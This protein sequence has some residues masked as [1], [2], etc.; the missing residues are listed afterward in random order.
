MTDAQGNS[1][2]AVR[3]PRRPLEVAACA[4]LLCAGILVNYDKFATTPTARE[5]LG[6]NDAWQYFGPSA[7][8]LDRSLHHGEF[9]LWNP[10]VYCG[11]PF[12]ANPQSKSFYPP[13][14]VRS[15]LTWDPTPEASHRS[16]K[17]LLFVHIALGG[18][19][20]FCLARTLGLSASAAMLAGYVFVFNSQF[21]RR[22]VAHHYIDALVW[23]PWVLLFLEWACAATSRAARA[24]FIVCGAFALGMSALAGYPQTTIYVGLATLAYAAFRRIPG[25]HAGTPRGPGPLRGV[26]AD[27]GI[28]AAVSLGAIL[29]ASVAIVPAIELFALSS[30]GSHGV[31][32]K[33]TGLEITTLSDVGRVFF[34]YAGPERITVGLLSGVAGVLVLMSLWT[35]R[36]RQAAVWAAVMLPLADLAIGTPM[37]FSTLLLEYLPFSL[38]QPQRMFAILFLPLGILAG[39]GLDAFARP[40]HR[41]ASR[42]L[43][44]AFVFVIAAAVT[45]LTW[46]VR[47]TPIVGAG[48][49]L[50]MD[51]PPAALVVPP[52]LA[53]LALAVVWRAGTRWIGPAVLGLAIC[54]LAVWNIPYVKHLTDIATVSN[55]SDPSVKTKPLALDNKRFVSPLPNTSIAR[56]RPIINGY[57]PSV[58]TATW[59]AVS[60]HGAE[61]LYSREQLAKR[62]IRDNKY[63][64]LFLWRPFWLV[65]H[66]SESDMP[67]KDAT[68]VPDEVA[69][70]DAPTHLVP[71]TQEFRTSY[72]DTDPGQDLMGAPMELVW[73]GQM[74][75][76]EFARI[77]LKTAEPLPRAIRVTYTCSAGGMLHPRFTDGMSGE[78]MDAQ[79][80]PIN[81]ADSPATVEFLV[82]GTVEPT[83]SLVFAPHEASGRV[84]IHRVDAVTV[85]DET[86]ERLRVVSWR[87]NEAILWVEDIPAP[88]LLMFTDSIYPGWR[89]YVD[90]ERAEIVRTN[91]AFKGVEIPAGSHA[92]RF[93]FRPI[94]ILI[95]MMIS[96]FALVAASIVLLWAGRP[97]QFREP[98]RAPEGPFISEPDS[99]TLSSELEEVAHED[100]PA[101]VPEDSTRP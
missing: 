49:R 8:F 62:V 97:R 34:G 60:A 41:G 70:V 2:D 58:P 61:T 72:F 74:P 43:R 29:L 57:E 26:T 77:E 17:A 68:F 44:C 99:R 40:L 81:M 78:P 85:A 71:K 63:T 18:L 21:V 31:T 38:A 11:V 46:L 28:L 39:F 37:P 95:G 54:D 83:F 32:L 16:V 88:R 12:A 73:E 33:E 9:P 79:V 59:D 47:F 67:P 15:L 35:A 45:Y 24:R 96:G 27:L 53:I 84:T 100:E 55:L 6:L 91:G 92:V 98:T 3:L 82:P 5:H 25:R 52:L 36:R 86:A 14:L 94:S 65:K 56:W 93:E 89:A 23:L 1:T 87:A 64:S 76:R 50:A 13:H 90:G 19:G 80:Q 101:I 48:N 75:G 30:R 51:A 69:F 4:I 20:A 66:V 7:Y 42:Y 10:L 22:V